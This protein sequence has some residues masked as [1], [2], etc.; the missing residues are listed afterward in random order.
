M[1]KKTFIRK[2]MRYFVIVLPVVKELLSGQEEKAV[3]QHNIYLD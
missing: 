1:G 2:E 3:D